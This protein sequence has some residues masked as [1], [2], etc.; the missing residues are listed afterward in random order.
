MKFLLSVIMTFVFFTYPSHANSSAQKE[1]IEKADIDKK[2]LALAESVNKSHGIDN[3]VLYSLY[4]GLKTDLER[5]YFSMYLTTTNRSKLY[6]HHF[7]EMIANRDFNDS[8]VSFLQRAIKESDDLYS[9]DHTVDSELAELEMFQL[10]AMELFTK[11]QLKE[12]FY[13]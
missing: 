2:V 4:Q 7:K 6:Q 5:R 10:Q 13:L 9:K 12:L 8:Q 3:L 1:T 11:E